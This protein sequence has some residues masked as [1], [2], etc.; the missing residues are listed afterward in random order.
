MAG[1][2]GD[3]GRRRML[4]LGAPPRRHLP[5]RG[6]APA[7]VE[8]GAVFARAAVGLV[9]LAA[10]VGWLRPAALFAFPRQR[11]LF[12]AVV[13]VGYPILSAWPQEIVFRV[14]FLHRYRELGERTPL[15][16]ASAIAFAWAHVVMRNALA[17]GVSLLGGV[18]FARTYARGRSLPL[19]ALEHAVW[20]DMLFAVG[21]GSFFYA[22][23]RATH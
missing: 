2:A 3:L 11:P 10:A 21:L 9:L 18:L 20:G 5:A 12:F 15:Y 13:L 16:L 14:F 17:V 1:L 23:A 19:V 7:A 6:P 8:V 22:G 4:P